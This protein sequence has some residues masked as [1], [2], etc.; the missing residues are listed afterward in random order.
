M[1][2]ACTFPGPNV[3]ERRCGRVLMS[4]A[5]ELRYSFS[6]WAR[7][8]IVVANSLVVIAKHDGGGF[9]LYIATRGVEERGIR[10]RRWAG[11]PLLLRR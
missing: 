10:G 3:E 7:T 9:R 4:A 11:P 1:C 6:P 2:E 5:C 8:F